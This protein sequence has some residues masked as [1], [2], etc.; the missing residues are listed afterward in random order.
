MRPQIV[1]EG[2]CR[3]FMRD[4]AYSQ[5]IHH[6][7]RYEVRV[8]QRSQFDPRHAILE[9][10][11]RAQVGC[12]SEREARLAA[13]SRARDGQESCRSKE[14]CL[15]R[16]ISLSRPTKLVSATGSA[17]GEVCCDLPAMLVRLGIKVPRKA[18]PYWT[19]IF[20]SLKV[21]LDNTLLLALERST[22][23]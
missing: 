21:L 1:G 5:S 22:L 15:S 4:L 11:S 14:L 6:C 23:S 20:Y 12:D 3:G 2:F 9:R 16:A 13:S 18:R 10:P 7:T 19:T 17:E 8:R